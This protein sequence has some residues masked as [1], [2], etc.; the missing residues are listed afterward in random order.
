ML[1]IISTI[2]QL[3]FH[4]LMQVYRE[5]N[6]DN[7]RELYP[8]FSPEEQLANAEQD[9]YHYL[10]FVFF[11]QDGAF[12]A[13]WEA[14]GSYKSALRIEAYADGFLLC[15][16]ETAPGDR[17][18]GYASALIRAVQNYLKGKGSGTIYSHVSKK[19]TA[20]LAVHRNCGFQ[21]IKDHAVY[22]DGSVLSGSFTLAYQ[23]QKSET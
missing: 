8:D 3:H 5:G 9:F 22:S 12:Y 7:G 1:K 16:L 14:E 11:K 4:K 21:V 13:I 17:C 15:A 20:S 23:Y 10:N 18:R 2:P 6:V 19:N